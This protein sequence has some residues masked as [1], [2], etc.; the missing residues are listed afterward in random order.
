M[1]NEQRENLYRERKRYQ[2]KQG[3]NYGGR[4]KIPIEHM[5]REIDDIR[6]QVSYS[7]QGDISTGPRYHVIQVATHGTIMGGGNKQTQHHRNRNWQFSDRY[8][9]SV[10]TS[11][12]RRIWSVSEN[13][14]HTEPGISAAK[15]CDRNADTCC[16]GSNFIVL[17]YTTRTSYVYAYDKDIAPLNNVP[18]VSGATAWDNLYHYNKWIS[19]LW[20]QIIPFDNKFKLDTSIWHT[21]LGQPIKQGEG[22]DYRGLWHCIHTNAYIW[23][24]SPLWNKTTNIKGTTR[25]T[26]TEPYRK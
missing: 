25:V 26:K 3:N 22:I 14:Q 10:K 7:V 13:Q 9:S 20:N 1:K 23:D 2:D 6:S 11:I 15:K 8:V 21:I 12:R 17:E 24:Q 18:I 4:K 16:L 5:Q 19:V